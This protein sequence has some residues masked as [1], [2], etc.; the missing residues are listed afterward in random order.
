MEGRATEGRFGKLRGEMEGMEGRIN[1]QIAKFSLPIVLALVGL[2][3]AI[4]VSGALG[5]A[6]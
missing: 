2:V 6:A 1:S 3:V 4:V 5:G